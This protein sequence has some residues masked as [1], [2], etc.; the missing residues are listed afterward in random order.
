LP[1]HSRETQRGYFLAELILAVFQL[2][3][4]SSSVGGD[5]FSTGSRFVA[6]HLGGAIAPAWRRRVNAGGRSKRTWPRVLSQCWRWFRAL[7]ARAAI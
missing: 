4:R 6:H 7:V 3:I 1:S 5:C 2:T